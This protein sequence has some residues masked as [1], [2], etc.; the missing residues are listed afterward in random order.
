MTIDSAVGECFDKAYQYL[1]K[2]NAVL[3]DREAR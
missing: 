2:Y 1:K 3:S